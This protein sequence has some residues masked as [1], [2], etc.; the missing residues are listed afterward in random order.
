M[1]YLLG[2]SEQEES[3]GKMSGVTFWKGWL[4]RD[5]F[6]FLNLYKNVQGFKKSLLNI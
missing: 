2:G 5:G 1:G 4:L 6:K 3:G